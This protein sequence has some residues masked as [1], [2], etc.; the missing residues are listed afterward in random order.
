[1]SAKESGIEWLDNLASRL[2]NEMT[3]GDV[4]GHFDKIRR[5]HNVSA[6]HTLREMEQ[7]SPQGLGV[8]RLPYG[9]AIYYLP[10]SGDT[11]E[12]ALSTVR[13]ATPEPKR[14]TIGHRRES[15]EPVHGWDYDDYI[16]DPAGVK[17]DGSYCDEGGCV[18]RAAH[19]L[20]GGRYTYDEIKSLMNMNN[21]L[22]GEWKSSFKNRDTKLMMDQGYRSGGDMRSAWGIDHE[23]L[24]YDRPPFRKRILTTG[25][26]KIIRAYMDNFNTFNMGVDYANKAGHAYAFLGGRP[27]SM[28]PSGVPAPLLA[29]DDRLKGYDIRRIQE[30]IVPAGNYKKDIPEVTAYYGDSF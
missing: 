5:N 19:S 14:I 7:A 29:P 12:Y 25:K 13:N 28:F 11:P 4:I 16:L 10:G 27:V 2:G 9:N 23:N 8:Q 17:A 24:V 30:I 18:P 21:E 15:N 1:M 3:T 26:E 6:W 22:A 20:L